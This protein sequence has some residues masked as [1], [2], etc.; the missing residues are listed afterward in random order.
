M[1]TIYSAATDGGCRSYGPTIT[2]WDSVHDNDGTTHSFAIATAGETNNY[3][4]GVVVNG[5]GQYTIYRTF[6][7]FDVSGISSAPGSAIF[8]FKSY[9]YANGDIIAVKATKPDTSTNLANADISALTGYTSGFNNSNLTAYSAKITGAGAVSAYHS[10]VLNATALSDM[11]AAS[12]LSLCLMNYDHDYL[13][14]APTS[15]S[16]TAQRFGV[17]F[18]DSSGTSNDPYIEYVLGFSHEVSGVATGDISE[19][20]GVATANIASRS[21]VDT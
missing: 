13:D 11:A 7:A 17:Y 8:K 16:T 6:F 10:V 14:S 12:T 4:P 1:P 21:G 18:A 20:S 2:S 15:T 5:S 3:G 9:V 19:I